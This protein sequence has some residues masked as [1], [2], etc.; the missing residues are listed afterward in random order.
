MA[1]EPKAVGA[2]AQ[3]AD[4]VPTV[5]EEGVAFTG[6]VSHPALERASL[7]PHSFVSP[8]C[9]TGPGFSMSTVDLTIFPSPN[10]LVC[11]V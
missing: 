4:D 3:G 5:S 10:L 6:A 8:A 9:G 2:A 1:A 11:C 7:I